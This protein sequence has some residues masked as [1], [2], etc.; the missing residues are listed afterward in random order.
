MTV[1]MTAPVLTGITP[2]DGPFCQTSFIVR[3]FV[4]LA[5]QDNPPI[6]LSSLDLNVER[7]DSPTYF[8]VREFSGFASDTN[9]AQEGAALAASVDAAG[10]TI[11]STPKDEVYIIA[12]YNS[13]FDITGRVNEVWLPISINDTSRLNVA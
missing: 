13:P 12:Q 6:P 4:P 1:N 9:V 10:F 7:W 8:A 3:F 11:S 2:S 5:F